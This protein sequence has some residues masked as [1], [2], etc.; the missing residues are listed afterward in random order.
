MLLPAKG[1]KHTKKQAFRQHVVDNQKSDAA[2]LHQNTAPL[3][4]FL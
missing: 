1:V 2:I 3:L 4:L